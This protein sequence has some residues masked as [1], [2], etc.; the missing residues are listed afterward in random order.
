MQPTYSLQKLSLADYLTSQATE[1]FFDF[2]EWI[3]IIDTIGNL[4][5]FKRGADN[6]SLESKIFTNYKD[7][8]LHG[9]IYIN[10]L[11]TVFGD[12]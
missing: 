3:V 9:L 8:G 1:H 11:S 5:G 7:Y 2:G 10:S 6:S 12:K 4:I